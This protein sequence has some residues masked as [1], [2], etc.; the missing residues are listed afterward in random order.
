M[1]NEQLS[2]VELA[3]SR[4]VQKD[5]MPIIVTTANNSAQILAQQAQMQNDIKELFGRIAVVEARLY[6]IDGGAR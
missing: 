1:S 4:I 6:R 3:L 2:E 5:I